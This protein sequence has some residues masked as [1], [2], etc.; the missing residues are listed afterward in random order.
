MLSP[1]QLPE[2]PCSARLLTHHRPQPRWLPPFFSFSVLDVYICRLDLDR[3]LLPSS[4]VDGRLAGTWAAADIMPSSLIGS[5]H[6]LGSPTASM[7]GSFAPV[8]HESWELNPLCGCNSLPSPTASMLAC[9]ESPDKAGRTPSLLPPSMVAAQPLEQAPEGSSCSHGSPTCG[10]GTS[11]DCIRP[12]KCLAA[13]AGQLLHLPAAAIL[14]YGPPAC[15]ASH[16]EAASPGAVL[17]GRRKS[18]HA[19][20]PQ[21]DG[22]L[23][24]GRG[25]PL[26]QS[27]AAQARALPL[28]LLQQSAAAMGCCPGSPTHPQLQ[29]SRA[30]SGCQEPPTHAL[31]QAPDAACGST[32]PDMTDDEAGSCPEPSGRPQLGACG[33]A[34]PAP[35]HP[36]GNERDASPAQA[37]DASFCL[38]M[39]HAQPP[40]AKI[41]QCQ[42]SSSKS[43]MNP[44]PR[45]GLP[46]SAVQRLAAA[47]PCSLQA[48]ITGNADVHYLDETQDDA[49]PACTIGPPGCDMPAM[50]AATSPGRATWGK[51]FVGRRGL[52]PPIA[53]HTCSGCHLLTGQQQ[54]QMGSKAGAEDPDAT[55]E[56]AFPGLAPG[57]AQERPAMRL[58]LRQPP[59]VGC[60]SGQPSWSPCKHQATPVK[61]ASDVASHANPYLPASSSEPLEDAREGLKVGAVRSHGLPTKSGEQG[62]RR[63]LDSRVLETQV[64][65]CHGS[66]SE[67]NATPPTPDWSPMPVKDAHSQWVP[68]KSLR[69]HSQRMAGSPPEADHHTPKRRQ[70]KLH[71]SPAGAGRAPTHTHSAAADKENLGCTGNKQARAHLNTGENALYRYLDFWTGPVPL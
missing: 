35:Q 4:Q 61:D 2:R 71:K 65:S 52:E 46:T 47:E 5:G 17:I 66:G 15:S 45:Q 63:A 22:G 53:G 70:L 37:V 42:S 13:A 3:Q 14:T 57:I 10:A 50:A 41:E 59:G 12:G 20:G 18:L 58:Q 48:A 67:L 39:E 28:Q 32:D 44:R 56:A 19:C 54:Q 33:G 30:M 9:S 23:L 16:P 43:R 64:G 40:N 6:A 31:Q 27:P 60:C 38:R 24:C 49:Q 1:Y 51:P 55:Q 8:F 68:K 26:Q 11:R 7:M 34:H 36:T 25:Q 62:P 29:D 21:D 69:L